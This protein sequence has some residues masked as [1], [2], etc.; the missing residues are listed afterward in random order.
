M[1][2]PLLTALAD[3]GVNRFR[4]LRLDEAPGAIRHPSFLRAERSHDGPLTPLVASDAEL[5]SA[6][7][8]L[9]AR[10]R[11][12]ARGDVLAVEWCDTRSPDGLWRKWSAL[13]VGDALVPRHVLVARDWVVKKP[14]LVNDDV[15]REEAEFIERF[16]HRAEVAAVF[17][18]AGVEY[19]RIDYAFAGGRIQ[20]FEINTNPVVVPA[21]ARLAPERLPSQSRSAALA[22]EALQSLDAGLPGPRPPSVVERSGIWLEDRLARRRARRR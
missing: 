21:P 8:A 13:R 17:D 3:R 6:A 15:V 11:D 7:Q 10:R 19:G 22:L 20:V 2:Y 12:L 1:R 4:A 16:P 18:L 14:D 5:A 9:L